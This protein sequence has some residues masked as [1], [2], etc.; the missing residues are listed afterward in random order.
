MLRR[1]SVR[2][3]TVLIVVA[4]AIIG[5]WSIG[6]KLNL[7][8]D[9]KGGAHIVLQTVGTDDNPVTEDSIDRLL[10]VIRNRIDQY[11]VAEPLIQKVGQDRVIV[12]L[13]GIQDPQAALDLIGRTAN[14]EFRQV[15]DV[16]EPTPPAP[17]RENYKDLSDEQFAEYQKRW[18]NAVASSENAKEEFEKRVGGIPGGIVSKA[19][20]ESTRDR[21]RNYYLLGPVLVGGKDLVDAKPHYDNLGRIGVSLKF[22][23]DGA[24]LFDAAT[25]ANVGKQIAIALDG[26]T[27]S[28]PVVQ[29]R[30]AG[31]EA[32]ITGSFSADEANR[33]A[34][35]LR[36]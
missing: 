10:A 33:L 28:A 30:I 12:D 20:T 13:P 4:A 18:E 5:I 36:A 22:N 35:M 17:R 23:S 11:G 25:A 16:S 29:E 15:V 21:A 14:L 3:W 27:V 19:D 7:G 31:G 24:K 34:I 26:V 8:L 1:D 2:L 32:Q 6:G 9:L